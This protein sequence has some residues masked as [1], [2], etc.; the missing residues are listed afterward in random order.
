MENRRRNK[1]AG[2]YERVPEPAFAAGVLRVFVSCV[3][4][5]THPDCVR[6]G[7]IGSAVAIQVQDGGRG[8]I[9][10]VELGRLDERAISRATQQG[11]PPPFGNAA[12]STTSILPSRSKSAATIP[13]VR[14]EEHT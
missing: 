6:S 12:N 11:Y 8:Q 14:S 4:H 7:D 10:L 1:R 13:L 5:P 2:P 9:A 3:Q